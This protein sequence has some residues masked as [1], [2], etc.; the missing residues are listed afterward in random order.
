MAG[1]NQSK[2]WKLLSKARLPR[3]ETNVARFS[4]SL[5]RNYFLYF[6]LY[7]VWFQRK[8][9]KENSNS[10]LNSVVRVNSMCEKSFT[11]LLL[12]WVQC[13]I[14]NIYI[15]PQILIWTLKKKCDFL[16]VWSEN[17]E[18]L[19]WFS[20][21]L[22]SANW[23]VVHRALM[24]I[25]DVE[26]LLSSLDAEYYDILMKWVCSLKYWFYFIFRW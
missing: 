5:Y 18:R 8:L 20:G 9:W 25:K 2:L 10:N 24:A 11:I 14:G 21:V 12:S 23:I 6:F 13:W 17:E 19:M 7:H 4:L 16:G 22:Q 26:G 1:L 3:P 15:S